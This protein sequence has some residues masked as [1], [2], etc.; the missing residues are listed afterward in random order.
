MVARKLA[1]IERFRAVS[2]AAFLSSYTQ[3]IAASATL[4]AHRRRAGRYSTCSSSM[5]GAYEI[6]YEAASRPSW[7]HVPLHGLAT[8]MR[9]LIPE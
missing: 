6:A 1:I 3:V 5:K 4:D 8:L 9:R 7:L 2:E